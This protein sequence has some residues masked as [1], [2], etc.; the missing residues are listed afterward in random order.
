MKHTLPILMHPCI[1]LSILIRIEYRRVLF[2]PRDNK[3]MDTIVGR[4]DSNE[5]IFKRILDDEEF[6]SVL[7]DYYL[8]RVYERLRSQP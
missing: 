8:H 7:A 4:M 6:Q 2:S 5:E 1:E 3:F